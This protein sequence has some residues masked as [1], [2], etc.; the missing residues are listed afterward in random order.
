[1]RC[2]NSGDWKT[3]IIHLDDA[4]FNRGL[5]RRSDMT[6]KHINGDDTLFHMIEM[7]RK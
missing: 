6:I 1:V 5:E 7:E 4:Y 2:Q 3:I